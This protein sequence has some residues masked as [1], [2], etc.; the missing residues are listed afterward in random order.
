[1][2]MCPGTERAPARAGEQQAQGRAG[3]QC[4]SRGS[5][6]GA[7]ATVPRRGAPSLTSISDGGN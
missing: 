1:M 6:E 2:E 4:R 5:D 7:Q 3:T